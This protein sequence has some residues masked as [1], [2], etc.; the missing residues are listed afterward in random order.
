MKNTDYT[1]T[2]EE[3]LDNLRSRLDQLAIVSAEARR[4]SEA[5]TTLVEDTDKQIQEIESHIF[6]V[7]S[8]IVD[9]PLLAP[10]T[11]YSSRL[12]A[13]TVSG[14]RTYTGYRDKSDDKVKIHFGDLVSINR[15]SKG[16]YARKSEGI[17]VERGSQR[18]LA[19]S[20]KLYIQIEGIKE[21]AL[22]S[23]STILVKR[24]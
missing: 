5:A 18:Q 2:I 9:S 20:N 24:K 3:E 21:P 17:V 12:K 4:A 10:S 23:V 6:R 16:K 15:Y 7:E 22:R 8:H 13:R 1:I 11:S 19:P 14:S